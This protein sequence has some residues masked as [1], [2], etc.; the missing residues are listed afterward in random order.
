MAVVNGPGSSVV[1]NV[2]LWDD[3]TG[4]TVSDSGETLSLQGLSNVTYQTGGSPSNMIIGQHVILHSG[5]TGN[6]FIG[7]TAGASAGNSTALTCNNTAVGYLT[8]SSLTSGEGNTALGCGALDTLSVG[9]DNVA[10]GQDTLHSLTT[11]ASNVGVGKEALAGVVN[12]DVNVGVG[13]QALDQVTS[14]GGNVG[15]GHATGQT[16]T[17]GSGNILI[18]YEADVPN[19]G[20]LTNTVS[21]FLNLGG[22]IFATGMNMA[23]YPHVPAGSVGI[24]I[25]TPAN[26]LSVSPLQYHTGTASQSGTTVTGVGT[27]WTSAMVGSQFIF[28]NNGLTAG[29]ITAFGSTTSL[30][31]T[32]SQSVASQNYMINYAGL[33][34][35]SVGNVGIGNTAPGAMLDIGNA[36][37]ALGTLR[38]E[39]STSGYVQLQPA[40]AAGSW[41]MTLPSSAGTN[42]YVLQTNGSGV[43]SWVAQS[44][45]TTPAGSSGQ[46]Q[47]NNSGSFG[48]DSNFFWDSTNHRLGVGTTTPSEK[49]DV[50]GNISI[51][52][53]QSQLY[54]FYAN[55]SS[56]GGGLRYNS[57]YNG[58]ADTFTRNGY[59]GLLA[60]N[61]GVWTLNISNASGT[62]GGAITYI[63]SPLTALASGNVGIG[64]TSPQQ[65]L[66]VYG[67]LNVDQAQTNSG[68]LDIS[69]GS[70]SGEGFGSKRTSGGNQYG[71][72]FFTGNASRVS[73]TSSG[74]V[75]IGTSTVT[76]G[77]LVTISGN[78]S[79][80]PTTNGILGTGTN[81][82]ASAGV[83]GEYITANAPGVSLT[84]GTA[85]NITSISLT[86]GDW[87]VDGNVLFH[88]SSTMTAIF[89]ASNST[90][91]S[92]PSALNYAQLHQS[93]TSAADSS[94]VVPTQ[95]YSLSSTTT[96]YLIGQSAFS[97]TCT[98][99]G[100]IRARRVR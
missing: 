23:A 42:G 28:S 50:A 99:S 91:A 20:S 68:G 46:I 36:G 69:L 88:P 54:G 4:T 40:V 30:T 73:I 33:Q 65:N 6:V 60:F 39:G 70:G 97:G 25:V 15:I 35:T 56:Q 11:G 96:I 51:T 14:G 21:N 89:A 13:V 100:L 61:N 87:D 83:V 82:S 9:T 22:V 2:V 81:D 5:A 18:G 44:G 27:T 55:S 10:I 43:T 76:S 79:F 75:G 47:F 26:N 67:A 31:V 29:T 74:A 71:L 16:V 93:F 49:L 38:L 8:M 84:S 12:G 92:F 1:G 34:V 80:T 41:T 37:T 94:L 77:S 59:A 32:T 86:A 63:A 45:A 53:D 95:R 48:A 24:G 62:A 66:S 64:T 85:T 72:D 17:T 98:G 57:Y 7:E 78:L 52:A 58:T 3:T 90:S 19:D